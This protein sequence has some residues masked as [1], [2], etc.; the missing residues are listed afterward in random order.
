MS[1]LINIFE[2]DGLHIFMSYEVYKLYNKYF[3]DTVNDG[4][5]MISKYFIYDIEFSDALKIDEFIISNNYHEYINYFSKI[6]RK[7]KIEKIKM[8]II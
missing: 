4:K 1:N 7:E 6:K 8:E 5:F 3:S 2:G